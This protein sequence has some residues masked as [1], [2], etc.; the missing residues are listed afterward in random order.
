NARLFGEALRATEEARAAT[1]QAR[2][3][4][5]ER[6]HIEQRLAQ[7]EA[8]QRSFLRDVLAS[9][10][11]GK[12]R[13]CDSEAD[14]PERLTPV[15]EPIALSDQT[16]RQLRRCAMEAAQVIGLDKESGLDLL[17]AATEA[18]MNAV[19][20]AGGGTATVGTDDKTGIVQVCVTDEGGGIDMSQL[21]HATLK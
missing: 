4:I 2:R 20:H 3:E 13:L 11:D 6:K 18:G 12:L 1:E 17:T 10:T 21:P 14:L 5:E 8:H 15:S 7:S 16:L 19:V 9:V